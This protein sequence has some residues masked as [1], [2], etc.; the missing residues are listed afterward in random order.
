MTAPVTSPSLRV[1][2][3]VWAL[4]GATRESKPRAAAGAGMSRQSF[5]RRL[6][7]EIEWSLLEVAMLSAHFHVPVDAL[8]SGPRPS[9]LA[10]Y[11]EDLDGAGFTSFTLCPDEHNVLQTLSHA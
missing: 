8:I 2:E 9:L 10:L 11:P 1:S 6:D 5:Q 7:G 3:A 4:L